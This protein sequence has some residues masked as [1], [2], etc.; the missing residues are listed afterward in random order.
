MKK[1]TSTMA[2]L[3]SA[4]MLSVSFPAVTSAAMVDSAQLLGMEQAGSQQTLDAFLARDQ[5]REQLLALGVSPQMV[6][7]RLQGLTDEED[8]GVAS[9]GRADRSRRHC[10]RGADRARTGGRDR[11]LQGLLRQLPADFH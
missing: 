8:R 10:L 9:R 6:Q 1:S 7:Q 4:A 3:L 11:R 2:G 5:V